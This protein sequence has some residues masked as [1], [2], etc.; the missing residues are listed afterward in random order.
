MKK[1]TA[2]IVVLAML[3]AM[4]TGLIVSHAGLG[5]V[6][7]DFVQLKDA[8][9]KTV[10]D[11]PSGNHNLGNINV[12]VVSKGA[13][14]IYFQGWRSE[15]DPIADFGY[16]INGGDVVWG[17]G[18]YDAALVAVKEQTQHEYPLRFYFEIPIEEGE[19]ILI[20]FWYKLE[21]GEEDTF[22]ANWE[23]YYSN[24]S[25]GNRFISCDRSFVKYIDGQLTPSTTEIA[26]TD[27]GN[28]GKDW[29][30]LF[31]L[32]NEE[33]QYFEPTEAD[34]LGWK[35]YVTGETM[36]L[37]NETFKQEGAEDLEAGR[38]ALVLFENDTYKM[39][40]SVEIKIQYE[41]GD[42][43]NYDGI[44]VVGGSS[45][46]ADTRDFGDITAEADPENPQVRIF[47]WYVS[48]T[49]I[50]A[51]GYRF[52]DGTETEVIGKFRQDAC[53]AIGAIYGMGLDVNITVVPGVDSYFDL[54]V[55]FADGT[56]SDIDRFTYTY[57]PDGNAPT[58]APTEV[59]EETEAPTGENPGETD[60][61]ETVTEYP[62]YTT[63]N[64]VSTGWWINPLNEGDTVTVGFEAPDWFN[65]IK[66]FCYAAEHDTP[67]VVRVLNDNEDEVTAKDFTIRSNAAYELKFDDKVAP[68]WCYLVFEGGDTSELGESW[69]VLGSAD[70]P[71]EIEVEITGGN[72]NGDTKTHP[73]ITL[74]GC[75][76]GETAPTPE[77]TEAPVETEA[78]EVT[79]APVP[80]E[81]PVATE[82]PAS[83]TEEPK[84]T[85]APKKKGCGGFVAGGFA[86]VSVIACAAFVLRKK[87]N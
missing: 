64:G 29:I 2:I 23:Y 51:L 27:P 42:K 84:A 38:Y 79:E 41:T 6:C 1:I 82:E 11:Y 63:S 21:D 12:P 26:V 17:F 48:D 54:F 68:G 37:N 58:A 31:F 35:S 69:F 62:L 15:D 43:V 87:D 74:L 30:G 76:P 34:Y 10:A 25:A 4:M 40:N 24:V 73:Y 65:G 3:C 50:A 66:F 72:T 57:N 83:A 67:I 53:N 85:E 86:V 47:G 22:E 7:V 60:A 28:A 70:G 80:T 81:A 55:Q 33:L 44:S 52:A 75:A 56:K 8:D 77:V 20:E 9:G 71:E 32:D 5:T 16:S 14:K 61:P 49:E 36:Q 78:P 59:P 18:K 45:F 19:D 39:L 13:T 46:S